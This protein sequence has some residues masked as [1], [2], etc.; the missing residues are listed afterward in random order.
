MLL[1]LAEVGLEARLPESL[2]PLVSV[3]LALSD[4][5]VEGDVL[6]L[7]E[8]GVQLGGGVLQAWSVSRHE[9]V[10]AQSDET[11]DLMKEKATYQLLSDIA[12]LP[13]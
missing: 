11:G 4:E 6:V 13:V 8:N 9:F 12:D 10:A 5:V 2:L 3:D 7:L 1:E